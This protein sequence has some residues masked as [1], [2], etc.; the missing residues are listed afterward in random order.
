MGVL[1][2]MNETI[3]WILETYWRANCR[4]GLLWKC[5][6]GSISSLLL[7]LNGCYGVYLLSGF[8]GHLSILDWND[9]VTDIDYLEAI[10]PTLIPPI[11]RTS[12]VLSNYITSTSLSYGESSMCVY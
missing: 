2:T 4:S 7:F 10:H 6:K 9:T 1:W 8:A 3:A 5:S 11:S 12:F